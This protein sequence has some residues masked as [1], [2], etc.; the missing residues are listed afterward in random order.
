MDET[1]APIEGGGIYQVNPRGLYTSDEPGVLIPSSLTELTPDL[2]KQL[3][4]TQVH[5]DAVPDRVELPK[6]T[7]FQILRSEI[8]SFGKNYWRGPRAATDPLDTTC[9]ALQALQVQVLDGDATPTPQPGKIGW[10]ANQ[11]DR[12]RGDDEAGKHVWNTK[13]GPVICI[14]RK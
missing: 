9:F 11:M 6:G 4:Y 5:P 13:L 10:L 12:Y 8:F 1:K 3:W 2:K 7:K 14:E